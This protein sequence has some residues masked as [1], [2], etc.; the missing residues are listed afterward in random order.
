LIALPI[1][2]AY[3]T[4]GHDW[5]LLWGLSVLLMILNVALAWILLGKVKA[6]VV[7]ETFQE[8]DKRG[9]FSSN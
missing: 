5:P 8:H 6:K 3:P 7:V 9:S 1:F 2:Q 4:S